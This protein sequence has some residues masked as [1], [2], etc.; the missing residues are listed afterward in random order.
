MHIH[1]QPNAEK[2]LSLLNQSGLPVTGL[3]E[4]S[5]EDF[6]GCGEKNNPA[7]I[8]GVE[9]LEGF[10]LLRSLVVAKES[11]S[12]GCGKSLLE[13]AERYAQSKGLK[14]LHFN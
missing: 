7:G 1:Q 13:I 9:L 14:S 2:V 4:N 5:F 3:Q 8:V 6:L 12:K 10:G 11:R